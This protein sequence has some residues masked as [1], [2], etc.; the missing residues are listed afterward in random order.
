MIVVFAVGGIAGEGVDLSGCAP[1]SRGSLALLLALGEKFEIAHEIGVVRLDEVGLCSVLNN[2]VSDCRAVFDRLFSGFRDSRCLYDFESLRNCVVKRKDDRVPFVGEIEV[3][4]GLLN[5]VAVVG[6]AK[7]VEIERGCS[8]CVRFAEEN[9][10]AGIF[11]VGSLVELV[12]YT[13]VFGRCVEVFPDKAYL[14][15]AGC[16]AADSRAVGGKSHGLAVAETEFNVA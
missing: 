16:Q 2:M 15:A 5:V 11:F 3:D 6:Q 4:L 7:V 12:D 14:V 8:R 1:A 10:F 9:E 13:A